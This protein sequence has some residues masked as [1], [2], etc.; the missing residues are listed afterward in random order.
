MP[1]YLAEQ[2]KYVHLIDDSQSG[3]SSCVFVQ[4][5]PEV[6]QSPLF[7]MLTSTTNQGRELSS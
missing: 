5:I 7:H 4:R 3:K 2:V 6:A 1:K